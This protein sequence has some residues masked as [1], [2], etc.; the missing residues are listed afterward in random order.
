M[1]RSAAILADWDRTYLK[2]LGHL[3]GEYRELRESETLRE[4]GY[5]F[6]IGQFGAVSFY[7]SLKLLEFPDR[8][9]APRRESTKYQRRALNFSPR[10]IRQMPGGHGCIQSM[11]YDLLTNDRTC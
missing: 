6:A 7:E 5:A 11:V 4:D 9:L 8:R 10:P 1:Q 2:S 3:G